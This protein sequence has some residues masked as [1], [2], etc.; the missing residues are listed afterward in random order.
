[1]AHPLTDVIVVVPGIM[2]S[3]LHR[4][5]KPV[6]EP[7]A[8]GI[9]AAL[10]SWFDNIN[11]LRLPAGIDD[12]HPGDGVTAEDLIPDI[13]LPLGL[14]TFDLGYTRLLRFLTDTFEVNTDAEVGP[15]NLITFP[16]DWRLSNR[17]NGA[18]L[19]E[20]AEAALEEWQ[21]QGGERADSELIFICHSMGGLVARWYVDH[22]SG[23]AQTKAVITLGTPHRG[24]LGALDQL[25]NGV[26]KGPGPFKINLTNFARSLPSVHQLL[27]EYACIEHHDGLAKTSEV[28][29]PN[30]NAK[31]AGDAM[32]FHTQIDM[33]RANN[34]SQEYELHPIG[35]YEQPTLTTARL[36]GSGVTCLSTI[37]GVEERGD[38]TVP[39]LSFTPAELKPSSA[40][41][42]YAADNHAGLVHNQSAF[43]QIEGIL[44]ARDVIHRSSPMKLSVDIPEVLESDEPL[45]VR[46][47]LTNDDL[48]IEAVVHDAAGLP[49]GPAER[50]LP[51][52]DG[53]QA[54]PDLPGPGVYSVTVRGAGNT[55]G[56][57][58]PITSVLLI[59]PKEHDL[60]LPPNNVEPI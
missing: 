41:V 28:T 50:I 23:A 45:V 33:G 60:G 32:K 47:H 12:D 38:G 52:S 35:G 27:P 9:V 37:G 15:R 4:N 43:D 19:G 1:M 7:T 44:T 21:A 53:P 14:W 25:V 58:D 16:Y 51:T 30:V 54:T 48:P 46:A 24:A 18:R 10:R 2:G 40:G 56:Q 39:R 42:N 11:G 34:R 22:L 17:Y 26:R 55:V 57:I 31:M 49:I 13:R 59:W 3:V 36:N 29:L 5:G 20:V 6:W 8:G